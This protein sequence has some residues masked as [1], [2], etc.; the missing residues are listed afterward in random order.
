MILGASVTVSA[1]MLARTVS[2]LKGRA[3]PRQLLCTTYAVVMLAAGD[4]LAVAR[5]R[6]VGTSI[7]AA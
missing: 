3:T 4:I 2:R 1:F 7:S 6:C 5:D